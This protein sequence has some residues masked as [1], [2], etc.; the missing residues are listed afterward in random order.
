MMPPVWMLC[1]GAAVVTGGAFSVRAVPVMGWVFIAMGAVSFTL[2]AVYGNY[3]M[4]A[5]FGLTHIIFGAVIA[6]RYGG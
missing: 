3:L 5:S 6:R 4:A 1:Y 2:P